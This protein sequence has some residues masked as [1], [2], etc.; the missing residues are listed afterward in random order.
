M[1]R[2]G[3]PLFTAGIAAISVQLLYVPFKV[4]AVDGTHRDLGYSWV[5]SAPALPDGVKGSIAIALMPWCVGVV[6]TLLAVV[7]I[8]I[9]LPQDF[10][11]VAPKAVR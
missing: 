11:S 9:L 3:G 6:A 2:G 10:E 5:W 8:Y 1:R 7:L 4:L